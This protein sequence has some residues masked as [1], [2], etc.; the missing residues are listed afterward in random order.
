MT[1]QLPVWA[2]VVV[3]AWFTVWS[4]LGP[5]IGVKICS[6]HWQCPIKVRKQVEDWQENLTKVRAET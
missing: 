2:L 1:I 3:I 6:S 4:V 5:W